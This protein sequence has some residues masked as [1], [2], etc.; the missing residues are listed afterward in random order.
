MAVNKV[1]IFAGTF[2]PFTLGHLTIVKQALKTFNQVIILVAVN[3]K[4]KPYYS[5]SERIKFV[6]LSTKGLKGVTVD[7]T[8]GLTVDYAKK[9]K[10]NILVR[11][12]R[13]EIDYKY[14]EK[15]SKINQRLAPSIMTIALEVSSRYKNISS[16]KVRELKKKG[17]DLSP[18]VSKNIIKYL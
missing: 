15:M 10:V 18:Y 8:N 2:D 14:E 4:K 16:T 5:L 1:A 13:N 6:K 7:S 3:D 9:H 12:I 11:G 17:E